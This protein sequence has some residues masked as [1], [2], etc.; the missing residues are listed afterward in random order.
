MLAANSHTW[1]RSRTPS[2]ALTRRFPLTIKSIAC[3]RVSASRWSELL[4]A[5]TKPPGRLPGRYVSIGLLA[6]LIAAIVATVWLRTQP[7]AAFGFVVVCSVQTVPA[8]S[9]PQVLTTVAVEPVLV[10][11]IAATAVA[12]YLMFR[13]VR[14]TG[15][16]RQMPVWR[17]VSFMAGLALVSLTVLGPLSAYDHTF[18][19]VHM[20]QHFILV[21]IAPP[22]LLA[23]AP[24]T[25]LLIAAGR[26]RSQTWLYPVLHSGPFHVFSH[27]LVGL[28][29]FALIPTMWYLTPIFEASLDRDWLHF[30]GY[31]LFL[32][33]GIH[34]W[35][36]VVPANPTR[37]NLA[38]PIR[39]LYLL[40]LVPIHA[41][42]GLL[43]YEPDQVMYPA[44][45]ETIRAWGPSPLL[46][47]QAAGVLMFVGGE[48]LGLL[49]LVAVA[50]QWANDEERKGA[51][52]DR[53]LARQKRLKTATTKG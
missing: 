39:L 21:T 52:Y 49:A 38:Y 29:L 53:E 3:S 32:F 41:F 9:F 27:P 23:G 33:A 37:W 4:T 1:V 11:L 36:P 15:Y 20:L 50:V 42:L 8:P 7:S 13:S 35:W 22:L 46:D 2:P 44:L 18:L 10:Y 26:E 48:A 47:Q 12:Y 40:A 5:T 24:L 25:L 31:G 51:R 6:G 34:Y 17:L 43:F 30:G 14:A 45:Q 16:R 28:V 19:F